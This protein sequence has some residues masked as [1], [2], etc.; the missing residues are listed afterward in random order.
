MALKLLIL[1][2]IYKGWVRFAISE[3]VFSA[4]C[5]QSAFAVSIATLK[6]ESDSCVGVMG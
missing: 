4:R 6:G 5:G 3:N 1:L 2:Y